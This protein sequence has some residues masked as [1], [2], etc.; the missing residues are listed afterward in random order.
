MW[1]L[2]ASVRGRV[3]RLSLSS[4]IQ[5]GIQ[6]INLFPA[7]WICTGNHLHL[8]SIEYQESTRAEQ[9]ICFLNSKTTDLDWNYSRHNQ[10]LKYLIRDL[11][12]MSFVK[13]PS[14]WD[15]IPG[16]L[17]YW[18]SNNSLYS[19][20]ELNRETLPLKARLHQASASTWRQLS[21]DASDSVL[22][23]NNGVAPEWGCNPFWSYPLLLPATKLR[24][25]NVFTPVCHSVHSGGGPLSQHAPQVT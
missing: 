22:I 13:K 17:V 10:K 14:S 2:Y 23:E 11:L 25:G 16:M 3:S 4:R 8:V 12:F 5:R 24:Q 15:G 21:N 9:L 19:S 7:C 18:E 20:L 6:R 1:I